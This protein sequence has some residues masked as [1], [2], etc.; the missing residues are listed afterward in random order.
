M[1][2]DRAEVDLGIAADIEH[3][4]E[5]PVKQPKKRFIGRRQADEAAT[6]NGL[7]TGGKGTAVTGTQSSVHLE[8][9]LTCLHSIFVKTRSS[10]PKSSPSR[11]PRRSGHQCCYSTSATQLQLRITQDHSSY[12][13]QWLQKGSSANA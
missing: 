13:D 12:P 11:D 7:A 3:A 5:I 1:E 9:R 10:N 6:K 4:V 8:T 2:D